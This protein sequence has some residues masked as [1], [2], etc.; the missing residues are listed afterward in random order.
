MSDGHNVLG[1]MD[2]ALGTQEPG[3]QLRI[4]ARGTHGHRDTLAFAL[5]SGSIHEANL[6][7]LFD[8]EQISV[9]ESS[10]AI[11]PLHGYFDHSLIDHR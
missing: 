4:T 2:Q 8:C 9:L 11:P 1:A 10:G 6:E 7:C 5:L 3:C